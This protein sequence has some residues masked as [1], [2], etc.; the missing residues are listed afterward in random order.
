MKGKFLMVDDL[1][2]DKNLKIIF[3][4]NEYI[5]KREKKK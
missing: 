2:K 3:V 5:K 1:K 4:K